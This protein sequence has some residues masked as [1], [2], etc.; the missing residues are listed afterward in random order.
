MLSQLKCGRVVWCVLALR[1]W[2]WGGAT[3]CL[4]VPLF[5]AHRVGDPF[6]W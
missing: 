3:E 1:Q 2:V 6:T 5:T 4:C